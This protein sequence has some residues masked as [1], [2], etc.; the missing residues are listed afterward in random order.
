MTLP[1]MVRWIAPA[2]FLVA[3]TLAA[4]PADKWDPART[5]PPQ[6]V[7]EL[8][9][10]QEAV[11]KTVDKCTPCTVGLMLEFDMK[12]EGG[13]KQKVATAG[14]GVIVNEDGLVLTVG[15]V[16]TKP[17]PGSEVTVILQDGDKVKHVKGKTLG[18]NKYL[19]T[20]MVQ[21]TDKGPNDGKWPYLKPVKSGELK[22]GQWVVTLGHP[23]GWK[24]GRPPVVRLGQVVD[25]NTEEHYVRTNCPIVG[26]DSGGPLF[27]LNGNVVGI[28]DK[29]GDTLAVEHN[30]HLPIESYKLQWDRLAKGEILDRKSLKAAAEPAY[31]GITFDNEFQGGGKVIDLD[32]DGPAAAGGVK[33]NDVIAEFDGVKVGS[34]DDIRDQ[35]RKK[36]AGELVEVSVKRA[37]KSVVLSVKL[38]KKI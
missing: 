25:V 30:I 10:L 26:G 5:E 33:I 2:L 28:H 11:K 18:F 29:I 9:A 4:A 12:G 24:E 31:L 35:L 14:S 13:K 23:G 16:I 7:A 20:G 37:S 6:T 17:G 8:K 1:R 15:H 36:R 27:D 3:S 38:A 22:K 19:D 21:I 32:E 34:A